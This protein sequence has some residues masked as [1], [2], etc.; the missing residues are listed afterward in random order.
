MFQPL[1]ELRG[2]LAKAS[3]FYAGKIEESGLHVF[4]NF[5]HSDKSWEVGRFTINIVLSA[6][7]QNLRMISGDRSGSNYGQGWHRVGHLVGSEKDKWWHLKREE[8]PAD[9]FD[10]VVAW[11]PSSYDDPAVV[12]AEAVEDVTRD[13]FLALKKMNVSFVG[14]NGTG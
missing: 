6:D 1:N 4:L 13:V 7:E 10:M 14:K 12:I 3:T 8:D 5:Q 9:D 2:N 11:R